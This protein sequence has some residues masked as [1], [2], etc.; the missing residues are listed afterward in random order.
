LTEAAARRGEVWLAR[1]DKVRPLVVLTRDPL[2]SILNAVIAAPITST[3]RNLSTEVSVGP[4]DGVRIRSV[5]NLD[6]LQLVARSRLVRKVGRV[7]ASTLA[8]LCDALVI[9]VDCQ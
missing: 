5:A 1:L 2:G 4:E 9:A 3:V 7:R 8:A 6:N